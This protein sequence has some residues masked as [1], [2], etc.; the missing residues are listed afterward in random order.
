MFVLS[1]KTSNEPSKMTETKAVCPSPT[2]AQVAQHLIASAD[3]KLPDSIKDE[4]LQS[5][6]ITSVEAKDKE[7][8]PMMRFGAIPNHNS[9]Y[10]VSECRS[11]MK[12]LV[13]GVKT[14]T[15][16]T[17]NCKAPGIANSKQFQSKEILVYVRLL[18]YALKALDIYTICVNPNGGL[19]VRSQ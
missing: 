1:S 6:Y 2:S 13:C 14:I 3:G 19:Y 17:L 5:L 12:T 7:D 11:L 18:K 15:W 10:S 8:K 4:K 9:P 16:G